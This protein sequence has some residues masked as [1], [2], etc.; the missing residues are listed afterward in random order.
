ME[1]TTEP[2]ATALTQILQD[3]GLRVR[4]YAGKEAGHHSLQET[5]DPKPLSRALVHHYDL[6]LHANNA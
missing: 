3:L 4:A 1:E 2:L 5:L 6:G